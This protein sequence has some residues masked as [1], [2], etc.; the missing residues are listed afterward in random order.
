MRKYNSEYS[1]VRFLHAVP[2]QGPIDIY[3]NGSLFFNRVFF[4]QFTPYLYVPN[5][6]YEVTVFPTMKRE[7]PIIRKS[8]EVTS[9][10]LATLAL[11]GYNDLELLMIPE[12]KNDIYENKSKMRVI[13]LSPNIPKVN[14]IFNNEILFDDVDFREATKYVNMT[15]N[16]YNLDIELAQNNRLLRSNRIRI[17]P[18][19]IYSLYMLG[20]FANFQ[21]FRSLDGAAF[22][23]SVVRE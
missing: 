22:I 11:T 5:G 6:N 16:I 19:G 17:N 8:L 20:N 23:T 18:N 4:T 15:P 21:V 7:N 10:E 1:L 2:G 9:D 12:A 13:H 3:L 14:I